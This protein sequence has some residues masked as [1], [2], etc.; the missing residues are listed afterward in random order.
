MGCAKYWETV[1]SSATPVA[2]A[3]SGQLEIREDEH[4]PRVNN[5]AIEELM[6]IRLP[7][8]VLEHTDSQVTSCMNVPRQSIVSLSLI[9]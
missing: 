5:D 7:G 1:T 8:L 6:K 9:S 2:S 3:A 4:V